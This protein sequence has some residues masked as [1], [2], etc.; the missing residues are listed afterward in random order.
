MIS[1]RRAGPADHARVVEIWRTAVDATHD[2]LSAADRDAIDQEVQ[3]WLPDPPLWL[4]VDEHDTPVAFMQIVDAAMEALFVDAVH[5]RRG[6]G[7]ALVEHALALSPA[8]ILTTTVNEQNA[9]AVGFYERLGF[10]RTGRA[11]TDEQGR[12][13]PLLFLRLEA[14]DR[15]VAEAGPLAAQPRAQ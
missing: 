8:P 13:Y 6:I 9:Q 1:V 11:E 3:R 14:P 5:H 4:A 10:R 7:R 12:C 15:P 2:F